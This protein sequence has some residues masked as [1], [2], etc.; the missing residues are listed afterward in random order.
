MSGRFR[1]VVYNHYG[2]VVLVLT[3]SKDLVTRLAQEAIDDKDWT[4]HV[5]ELS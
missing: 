3:G 1:S 4:F 5:Q 2:L